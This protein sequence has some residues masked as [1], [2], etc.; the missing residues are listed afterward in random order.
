MMYG[1]S[2]AF[3]TALAD[4]VMRETCGKVRKSQD[5]TSGDFGVWVEPE[6]NEKN[7]KKKSEEK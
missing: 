1:K 6:N 2:D 5:P 3:W 4:D 7:K